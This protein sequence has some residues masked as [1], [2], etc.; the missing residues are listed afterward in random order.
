MASRRSLQCV[1]KVAEASGW[2]ASRIPST[3]EG[4]SSSLTRSTRREGCWASSGASSLYTPSIRHFS[5]SPPSPLPLPSRTTPSSIL[6]S[7]PPLLR[8]FHSSPSLPRPSSKPSAPSSSSSS[9]PPP[10]SPP[11]EPTPSA[12]PT[13]EP[14]LSSEPSTTLTSPP[15]SPDPKTGFLARTLSKLPASLRPPADA[16]SSIVKL[17]ALAKPERKPIAWAVALLILSSLVSMSV[18]MTIGKLIDFFS[19]T[20]PGNTLWGMTFPV[21]ASILCCAFAVGAAANA[22]RA[23]LMKTSGQRIIARVRNESYKNVLRQ[24]VEFGDTTTGDILS[25]LGSDTSIVGDSVTNNLSDGLRALLSGVVGIGAMLYISTKLTLVML[26]VIPPISLG[27]VFYG[28]YLRKLS[29]QTQEALGDMTKVAQEKLSSFRTVTAFNSQPMEAA[30]FS[31]KVDAVFQLA[32]KEAVA[33]GIFFGGTGLTGN[34]SMLCLLG[35]G[36]HLVSIS[37]I[38]V[39]SLTSML[40]YAGYVGGSVSGLTGFF[41]GLMKGVGAGSRVFELLDRKSLIASDVGTELSKTRNGDI[42]LEGVSF[43]YPSRKTAPVLQDVSFTIKQGTSVAIVGPS[44][45]G[46][47]SVHAL[48]L[49]YYDPDSGIITFDGED[50]R[51]FTATSWRNKLGIVPQDPPLFNGTIRENITYGTPRATEE[52]IEV[53]ARQANCDFIWGLPDGM[54]TEVGKASLSGGQKQRIAIARALVRN[55]SILLL[56]E[57]TSAL[58]SGAEHQVNQAISTIL[59]SR[60]I[61]VIL[62]AHRLSSIARAERVFVLEKGRVTEEGLYSDLATRE[63]SRFRTLMA[64]Q[65]ALRAAQPDISPLQSSDVAEKNDITAEQEE[66]AKAEELEKLAEE[67]AMKDGL[68]RPEEKERLRERKEGASL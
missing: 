37:E 14:I 66:D 7:L 3:F 58:D 29:K 40:I 4:K 20:D 36:G 65:L 24:E 26:A 15:P 62:V 54:D 63:N 25:R 41:T 59:Q 61:T 44:G 48:L 18:P 68:L 6:H 22:M 23:I 2:T 64:A 30:A 27:A 17:L 8:P 12:T 21:A 38:S 55:P 53:A 34:L 43:T 16:D 10:P 11:T 35:Y 42:T 33:S 46:K 28:R 47:S 60:S 52:E 19:N 45:S 31:T 57:A 50:I 49:R 5:T 56:D 32:K 51:N 1:S 67:E 39:G 9:S 13:S